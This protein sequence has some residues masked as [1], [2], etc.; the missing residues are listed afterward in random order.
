MQAKRAPV[1]I[2]QVLLELERAFPNRLPDPRGTERDD[3]YNAGAQSVLRWIQS[4]LDRTTS[5]TTVRTMERHELPDH[6][7]AILRK[8]F[9]GNSEL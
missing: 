6:N 9:G 2:Q 1:Q 5:E 7:E 3:L 8:A 4:Y